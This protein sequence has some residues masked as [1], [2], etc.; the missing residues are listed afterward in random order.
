MVFSGKACTM[1]LSMKKEKNCM[2]KNHYLWIV[3]LIVLLL[4]LCLACGQS[5]TK[6][7]TDNN[8]VTGEQVVENEPLH[9][10]SEEISIITP[11]PDPHR[12]E[13][14][15]ILL[16][17]TM[18]QGVTV[19]GV[20][21][22]GMTMD[23][24]RAA[25]LPSIEQAKKDMQVRVDLGNISETFSGESIPI[26]DNFD[27]A[28]NEAFALVREDNGFEAV[29]AEVEA[30][31]ASGRDF[32]VLLTFNEEA[33][34]AAVDVF[35]N[36]HE[37]KPVNAS[38]G[39]DSE[40]NELKI[41]D[42]KPKEDDNTGDKE[43]VKGVSEGY[44]LSFDKKTDDKVWYI[45]CKKNKSNKDKDDPKRIDLAVSK[46]DYST[47]YL[48]TKAK[49]IGISMENFKIGVTEKEVTFNPA[50][51]LNATIIDERK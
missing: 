4:V 14:N 24:A 29:S 1:I 42:A 18:L 7:T 51:Y 30:I 12:D 5:E 38:V 11:E 32:P 39:Y 3:P 37:T 50:D 20:S 33:L 9:S 43:L 15:A 44:D 35:A 28:L 41:T 10:G 21:V 40:K 31:K 48:K 34:R 47:I 22:G 27:D 36:E 25:V 23:E 46:A 6:A 16:R 17:T 26:I 8:P 49:G 13:L 19:N 2:K 45:V